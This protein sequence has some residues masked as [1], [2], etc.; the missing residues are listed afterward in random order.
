MLL[1]AL[2]LICYFFAQQLGA[3]KASVTALIPTFLGIPLMLLGYLSLA[4]PTMRKHFM[5]VAVMLSTLG[6]LASAGR[7][8]MVLVREPRFGVGVA[9]NA[10]MAIICLV[11]TVMCVRSFIAARRARE[12]G[13]ASA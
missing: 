5:H 8:I 1:S 2:G 12:S 13:A 3:E 4:K 7:L 6:L 10:I 11:F 9:A